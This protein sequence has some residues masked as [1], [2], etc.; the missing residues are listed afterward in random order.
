MVSFL[1]SVA[2]AAGQAQAADSVEAVIHEIASSGVA[3]QL[4]QP[5]SGRVNPQRQIAPGAPPLL[6]FRYLEGSEHHRFNQ[7]NLVIDDAG[8]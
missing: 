5:E 3:L 6:A 8:H 1:I 4:A 7:L 2:L